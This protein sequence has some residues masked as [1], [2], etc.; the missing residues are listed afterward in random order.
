MPVDVKPIDE[1]RMPGYVE[2]WITYGNPY[3]AAKEL[4]VLPGHTVTIQ[5]PGPVRV[6]H[7]A[8]PRDDWAS[9]RSRRRR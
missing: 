3:F 2:K 6:D 5:D 4:T 1:M 8:G 7:G 9:T